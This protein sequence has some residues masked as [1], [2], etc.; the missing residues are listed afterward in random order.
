MCI[1]FF[2]SSK[3]QLPLYSVRNGNFIAMLCDRKGRPVFYKTPFCLALLTAAEDALITI[4][5]ASREANIL[6]VSWSTNFA[7]IV[8]IVVIAMNTKSGVK[9]STVVGGAEREASLLVDHRD[10]YNVTV[11]VFDRCQQNF[12]SE[13]FYIEELQFNGAMST[14]TITLMS[15]RYFHSSLSVFVPNSPAL[16]QQCTTKETNNRG[17]HNSIHY[18]VVE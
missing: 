6:S 8:N 14:A 10:P 15:T 5:S 13:E 7:E 1:S 11:M 3:A 4:I 12:S 16:N 2:Y 17:N 9:G 18:S